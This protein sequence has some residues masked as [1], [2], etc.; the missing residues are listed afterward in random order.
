MAPARDVAVVAT[1][2]TVHR[3]AATELSEVEMIQ[4]VI[5][6]VLDAVGGMGGIDFTCS[7]STDYLAGQAFS[8]V[9]TLA[10]RC[11]PTRRSSRATSRWTGPGRC[12]RRG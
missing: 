8:F 10:P 7:G 4:P 5:A 1:A 9:M 2:Q 12:T 3:R 11:R 6:E